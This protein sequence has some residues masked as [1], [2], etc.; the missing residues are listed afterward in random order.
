MLHKLFATAHPHNL[1]SIVIGYSA[2]GMFKTLVTI[3]FS[4]PVGGGLLLLHW[5]GDKLN[6]T[7]A[8]GLRS[9]P[10]S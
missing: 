1:H 2:Q 9:T 6:F 10:R 8:D 7:Y 4:S 5:H 3:F